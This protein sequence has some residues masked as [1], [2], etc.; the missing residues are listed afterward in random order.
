MARRSANS[1]KKVNEMPPSS[2][3][4]DPSFTHLSAPTPRVKF[5]L[6]LESSGIGL[7]WDIF[8][9]GLSVVAM[10]VY[11]AST[12]QTSKPEWMVAGEIT[13][14]VFFACDYFLSMYLAENKLMHFFSFFAM[15]DFASIVPFVIEMLFT[16]IQGE[17]LAGADLQFLRLAR[18]LRI[19]RLLRIM[20]MY[21]VVRL[22]KSEVER[23]IME[24]VFVI[25]CLVFISAGCMFEAES[26]GAD[27]A[28]W[29]FHNT[30]YFIVV[31]LSTVGYGDISPNNVG[32]RVIMMCIIATGLV[33]VPVQTSRVLDLIALQKKY[34]DS[35]ML[36]P[37]RQHVVVVGHLSAAEVLG[38][39]KE[40][41][42]INHQEMLHSKKL[43]TSIVLLCPHDPSPEL[44]R[45]LVSPALPANTLKFLKGS[46]CDEHSFQR[47]K[48]GQAEAVFLL[49]DKF[50]PSPSK[51]DAKN[52][53]AL[54]VMI[55]FLTTGDSPSEVG[56]TS[57]VKMYCQVM[58]KTNEARI[59]MLPLQNRR[60]TVPIHSLK[61]RILA[62][63]CLFPGGL[64]LL[65]NLITSS[66]FSE[67]EAS[68]EEP[69]QLPAASST[70]RGYMEGSDY[71]VYSLNLRNTYFTEQKMQYEDAVHLIFENFGA[72]L[73]GIE[74]VDDRAHSREPSP[75]GP[76]VTPR[77]KLEQKPI[78]FA[79][80]PT[81]QTIE[82]AERG[83]IFA[84]SHKVCKRIEEYRLLE[85]TP[86]DHSTSQFRMSKVVPVTI[87]V[88]KDVVESEIALSMEDV[89]RK[90]AQ[91]ESDVRY[92]TRESGTETQS[93]YSSN[94]QPSTNPDRAAAIPGNNFPPLGPLSGGSNSSPLPPISPL[95]PQPFSVNTAPP[96]LLPM[97]E[98]GCN[99][100]M[101][102]AGIAR[103]RQKFGFL[104]RTASVNHWR[105]NYHGHILI[106]GP[107]KGIEILVH[108]IR[109]W[110]GRKEQLIVVLDD[111][112]T[113]EELKLVEAQFQERYFG[114]PFSTQYLGLD[115]D[116]KLENIFQVVRGSCKIPADLKRA[117]FCNADRVIVLSQHVSMQDHDDTET[118]VEKDANAILASVSID[119]RISDEGD[120]HPLI[121][122]ELVDAANVTYL[123]PLQ[124]GLPPVVEAAAAIDDPRLSRHF[125]EG[126]VWPYSTLDSLICQAFFSQALFFTLDTLLP[127]CDSEAQ[128]H[129][130]VS[131]WQIPLPSCFEDTSF[132]KMMRALLDYRVPLLPIGILR[133]PSRD[134]FAVPRKARA[135]SRDRA[136]SKSY[137]LG[138]DRHEHMTSPKPRGQ[139]RSRSGSQGRSNMPSEDDLKHDQEC[140]YTICCPSPD[141]IMRKD[142]IVFVIGN[143]YEFMG[144]SG[145]PE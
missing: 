8:Q 10:G 2:A 113:E 49:A 39:V 120:V 112:F 57:G 142:D 19:V 93:S 143:M 35:F 130:G 64:S 38:F 31:S 131:L 82:G 133:N 62:F 65:H 84:T 86:G 21:R 77:T 12:Y 80:A 44:E 17:S 124:C 52:I 32:G 30:V 70:F 73:I 24:L 92:N 69:V 96:N 3:S 54:T 122:Y 6:W 95:P 68:D 71:E 20:R 50:A 79:L 51:V 1:S 53:L 141:M 34:M 37:N 105:N 60:C 78:A 135:R 56:S 16:A 88:S 119:E 136:P 117:G 29:S 87:P 76:G 114:D 23:G 107:L 48:L 126:K 109:F 134:F 4:K 127:P 5:S 14:T 18:F 9:I 128:D 123:H 26:E 85:E 41:Y 11:V 121:I 89:R 111:Q 40:F 97:A 66:A 145:I 61:Q 47:A 58:E 129:Q 36:L 139:S 81:K 67:S 72:I 108:S 140:S 59:Q 43:F 90:L 125:A 63:G 25:V 94:T 75:L 33:I 132:K 104:H 102:V 106:C 28:V 137:N 110:P 15:I 7:V 118:A 115:G 13:L 42:H 103:M 100:P 91:L 55:R 46:I 144:L 116:L 101:D 74:K 83:Y 138:L 45:L 22:A 98:D 27:D 99:L